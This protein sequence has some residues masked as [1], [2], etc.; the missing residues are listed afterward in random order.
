MTTE[1]LPG[2]ILDAQNQLKKALLEADKANIDRIFELAVKDD[3]VD[4]KAAEKML[5]LGFNGVTL[6][7]SKAKLSDEEILRLSLNRIEKLFLSADIPV[8]MVEILLPQDI[9]EKARL[10]SLAEE[11]GFRFRESRK[12][13]GD[14][15]TLS[16][17]ENAGVE[18]EFDPSNKPTNIEEFKRNILK[19]L[20]Y[21]GGVTFNLEYLFTS[22]G[23][24]GIRNLTAGEL[25]QG[26]DPYIIAQIFIEAIEKRIS[27]PRTP[28]ELL[29]MGYNAGL[30]AKV[31]QLNEKELEILEQKRTNEK[32]DI[33][34]PG[35]Y[36]GPKIYSYLN[37]LD[38]RGEMDF[39]AI[40][41]NEK[42]FDYFDEVVK[43]IPEIN[44]EEWSDITSY[45][46]QL[47]KWAGD[48]FE[49]QI[50]YSYMLIGFEIGLLKQLAE[51]R[52]K[53]IS[54]IKDVKDREDR[55]DLEYGLN[56]FIA[57]ENGVTSLITDTDSVDQD[58][59]A[60]VLTIPA[61]VKTGNLT[62]AKD[63][64]IAVAN[65][66][67]DQLDAESAFAMGRQY[68]KEQKIS[69][70]T[71]LIF[72]EALL[73][74]FAKDRS[75]LSEKTGHPMKNTVS[76]II[77]G[78]INKTED[79]G[80]LL[81]Y[82]N[83]LQGL[84]DL[85]EDYVPS[86]DTV[87]KVSKEIKTYVKEKDKSQYSAEILW[88][89]SLSHNKNLLTLEEKNKVM[90]NVNELVDKNGLLETVGPSM[91]WDYVEATKVLM[92]QENKTT[93]KEVEDRIRNI[94]NPLVSLYTQEGSLP[95]SVKGIIPY[96]AAGKFSAVESIAALLRAFDLL[97]IER[98]DMFKQGRE[99][100]GDPMNLRAI[101]DA[102]LSAA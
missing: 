97:N 59:R 20:E 11:F 78:Q 25:P 22:P 44:G 5:N 43:D 41:R 101:A 50:K 26:F 24:E 12:V 87:D 7:F 64:L 93:A 17:D 61:L 58:I 46:A 27:E 38:W 66:I 32:K 30:N 85:G 89:I 88:A 21:K 102:L 34:A 4:V 55:R 72:I 8:D 13:D 99:M 77:S 57:K 3:K 35:L 31:P 100:I 48:D 49:E 18:V 92:A 63:L 52:D 65:S 1:C 33:S 76:R 79:I 84:K 73:S 10:I 9:Q 67:A 15:R 54:N 74:Y 14:I 90:S 23:E 62:E 36:L 37:S 75:I 2:R 40:S 86:Q 45:V 80:E 91:I 60:K 19:F 71:R 70:K 39:R 56:S 29:A 68:S 98:K 6:N 96:K 95:G 83:A 81:L 47:K 16:D 53:E 42:F 94:I 82:Y 69:E 28:K 51:M